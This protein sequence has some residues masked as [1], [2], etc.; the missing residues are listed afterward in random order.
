[1]ELKNISDTDMYLFIE[2]GLRGGISYIAKWYSEANN[3][4]IKNYDPT[5]PSKYISY[6]DMNN[7]YDWGMSQYFPYGRFKWLKNVDKFDVNWIS[8]TNPV[9]HILEVDLQHPD[10]LHALH[11]DYP[12]APEKLAIPYDI[13]SDY[14][15]TIA[16]RYEIKVGHVKSLILSL[17]D[18]TNYV[19]YYR[20]L[21]L[22][23]SLGMELTKFYK[24]LKF[25]QSEWTKN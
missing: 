17:G 8:E 5:K 9:G 6:L 18:K 25:K 19:V 14:C 12:L 23:L 7:L 3:K 4:Y 22:Y 16:D 20:N 13:L 11:N 21:E 10:K 2:K 24:V 1:M 15:K